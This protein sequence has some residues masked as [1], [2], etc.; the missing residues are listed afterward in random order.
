MPIL[1]GTHTIEIETIKDTRR[2][3]IGHG[4]QLTIDPLTYAIIKNSS[5]LIAVS[6]RFSYLPLSSTLL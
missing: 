3:R 5:F 2:Y 6:G 1:A 4:G